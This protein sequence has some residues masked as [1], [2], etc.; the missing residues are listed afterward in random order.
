MGGGIFCFFESAPMFRGNTIVTNT[1]EYGGGVNVHFSSSPTLQDNIIKNNTADH[2]GGLCCDYFSSP[3]IQGNSITGNSASSA[4]G[5][6][7]GILCNY[8]SSPEII[9]NTIAYNSAEDAGGIACHES[10]ATMEGCT[11]S[12]NAAGFSDHYSSRGG[13]IYCRSSSPRLTNCTITGNFAGLPG[14]AIKCADTSSAARILNSIL[15]GDIP[16]KIRGNKVIVTY[17]DVEGGWSGTGNKVFRSI[18]ADGS[19]VILITP[20]L[21]PARGTP[22]SNYHC[23]LVDI[24]TSGKWTAHGPASARLPL[25]QAEKAVLHLRAADVMIE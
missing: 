3:T 21:I 22:A 11:L 6:G 10:S 13:G 4:S 12:G 14:G 18:S 25:G 8:S 5:F 16:N 7:G 15:W 2:G 9:D 20:R 24:E 1:A 19:D 17:S 23:W